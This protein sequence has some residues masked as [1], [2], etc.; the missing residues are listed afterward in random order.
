MTF[1]NIK[2][3][4]ESFVAVLPPYVSDT[5]NLLLGFPPFFTLLY[6][7]VLLFLGAVAV[8]FVRDVLRMIIVVIIHSYVSTRNIEI[9]VINKGGSKRILIAGDSTAVGT[10]TKKPEETLMGMFARDFPDVE[11]HNIGMNA[12][13]TKHVILQLKKVE[14]ERFT[15]AIISTGGNDVWRLTSLSKLAR[16]LNIVLRLALLLTDNKVVLLIN[17][18]IGL[19]P[20]FPIFFRGYIAYRSTKI[21]QM[22]RAIADHNHVQSV[23]IFTETEDNPFFEHPEIL[24]SRDGIHPNPEGYRLWYNR[25]WRVLVGRNYG[26]HDQTVETTAVAR[27]Q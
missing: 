12:A 3:T 21:N 25:L 6:S 24:F 18:N 7:L 5:L 2:S 13:L 20:I 19:A 14:H 10:G 26:L 22:F 11:I 15:M 23:D 17:N 8:L 1:E 27:N 9:R 16:D 4:L